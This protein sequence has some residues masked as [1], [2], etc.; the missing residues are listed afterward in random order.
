MVLL[1]VRIGSG[2][3]LGDKSDSRRSGGGGVLSISSWDVGEIR[4]F[5]EECVDEMASVLVGAVA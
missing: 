4:G 5:E 3:A 2:S 1:T